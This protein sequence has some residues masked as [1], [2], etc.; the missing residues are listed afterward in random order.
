[1]DLICMYINKCMYACLLKTQADLKVTL[2]PR[3]DRPQICDPPAS[4]SRV[5]E[6]QA[7]SPQPD[8]GSCLNKVSLER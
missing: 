1:M 8:E 6:I 3:S 5:L 4:F 7:C 2:E